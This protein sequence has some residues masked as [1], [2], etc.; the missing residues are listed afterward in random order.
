ME[1]SF[2]HK[3]LRK[4]LVDELR[5]KGIVDEN[6]LDAINQ[7]PRHFF[8]ESS[9]IELSYKD[10]AFPIEAG[11]TISQPYTVAFQTCLLEVKRHDR[12]LE[13]GTGSGYQTAILAELGAKIFTIERQRE[14]FIKT[15]AFL[16]TL[17][18]KVHF[19]YGDGYEGLPAYAP[20]D[21]IL[22]TAAIPDIP[23]SLLGQLKVG[24]HLVAPIGSDYL[25]VMTLVIRKSETEYVRSS[26][27][28]FV[29]VPMLHGKS[30]SK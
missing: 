13:I 26:H 1:D 28:S 15:Q 3:G 7:V 14:L 20:F 24:G 23:K 2:R 29:F 4:K 17:G 6:V 9:F 18:Y 16:P 12:I 22:I 19:V 27:G 10:K 25:Q 21:G 30:N 8:M 11:Q 5:E